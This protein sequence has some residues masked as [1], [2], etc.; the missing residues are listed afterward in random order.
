MDN[1]F[2]RFC[3]YLKGPEVHEMMVYSQRLQAG[4]PLEIPAIIT[5]L[6]PLDSAYNALQSDNP[7]INTVLTTEHLLNELNGNPNRPTELVDPMP[8]DHQNPIL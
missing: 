2:K 4:I 5:P 7:V 3:I 8:T 6:P 1:P